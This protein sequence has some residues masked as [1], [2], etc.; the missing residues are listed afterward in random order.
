MPAGYYQL[1]WLDI[2]DLMAAAAKGDY[3]PVLDRL[4]RPDGVHDN[5]FGVYLATQCTDARWPAS[6]TGTWKPDALPTRSSTPS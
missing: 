6:Y 4:R 1:T 5:G 2:A 3:R